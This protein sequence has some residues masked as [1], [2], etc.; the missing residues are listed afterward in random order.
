M[1]TRK[2][3][4]AVS[5]IFSA[6]LITMLVIFVVILVTSAGLP[7]LDQMNDQMKFE[8]AR[9]QLTKI[10]EKINNVL[11]SENSRQE[12]QLNLSEM[13][14]DVNKDNETIEINYAL[15]KA[16]FNENNYKKTL[17]ELY[18]KRVGETMKL[19]LDYSNTFI[20]L[21]SNL[22][23]MNGIMQIV[24]ENKSADENY[25]YISITKK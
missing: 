2:A 20:N 21:D 15:E 18:W 12:I 17:N 14:L 7:L 23:M 13:Q 4:K 8:K 22:T 25:T 11:L 1:Q 24:I 9:N 3:R 16:S 6:V 10:N 19:G 5:P